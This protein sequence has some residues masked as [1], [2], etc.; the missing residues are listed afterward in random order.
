MRIDSGI[1]FKKAGENAETHQKERPDRREEPAFAREAEYSEKNAIRRHKPHL[2][3][4]RTLR[5][6]HSVALT[7]V[8]IRSSWVLLWFGKKIQ[9][10][11]EPARNCK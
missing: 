11:E 5:R 4:E 2:K 6:G 9:R 8:F 3:A 1:G 7:Y 10:I